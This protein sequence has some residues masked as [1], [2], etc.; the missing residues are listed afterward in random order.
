MLCQKCHKNLATVR[1]AEV[2]DG[3]VANRHLCGACLSAYQQD[4][5]TGFELSEANPTVRRPTVEQ[6]TR[7][8]V[9]TERRCVSCGTLEREVMD[10]GVVGCCRCYE[11]FGGQIE[12]I[13]EGLHRSLQHKGKVRHIDD[14]RAWLRAELQTKRSLLRSVL[15]TEDY[16]EAA[17]LR[18]EIRCLE[19]GLHVSKSGAG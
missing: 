16:E 19:T 11:S 4:A 1:Y 13:L 17:T 9:R 2:V 10:Q 18:D 14:D 15:A 8:A 5:G 7:D 3:K 6:V 12:S